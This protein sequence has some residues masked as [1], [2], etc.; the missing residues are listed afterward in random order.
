MQDMPQ[1]KIIEKYFFFG[2]LV[3][4]SIFTFFIFRPF[5]VVI[6]LGISFAIVLYPAYEWLN[7]KIQASWASALLTVC[8]FAVI[9]CGP[10]LAMGVMVFNQSEEVYHEIVDEGSAKPYLEALE[11]K[12]NDVLPQGADFDIN[13]KVSDFV[14]YVSDNISKIFKTTVSAFFSF[15][16]MLLIIFHFLKDGA[17]WRKSIIMLSPLSDKEDEK[18]I[19]RLSESVNAV[20]KGSLLVSLIQGVLMGLGLALFGVPHPAL[21]GMVAA[22]CSLIPTVGTALVSVPSILFLYASGETTGAIGL[23]I[24]AAIAVGMIDNF[25]G[26]ILIGGKIK[27]SSILILFSA[28]GGISLLGPAGVLVGPLMVSFLYTLI[29]IYRNEFKQTT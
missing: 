18:I 24:W 26:P 12:V 19:G 9:L 27:I 6:V 28:L 1:T 25:L 8:L 16:L 10:L 23:L 21:W 22:V 5:W 13:S 11:E 2:L 14:H 15:L 17:E 4:T 29:S 3:G 20:M 7:R